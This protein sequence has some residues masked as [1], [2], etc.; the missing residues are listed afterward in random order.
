M[1]FKWIK[2]GRVVSINNLK[3]TN[4]A[5]ILT[6]FDF[7]IDSIIQHHKII[8]YKDVKI[9]KKLIIKTCF[10]VFHELSQNYL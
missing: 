5:K 7:G 3:N 4:T 8:S 2:H 1:G 6:T 10:K 9:K